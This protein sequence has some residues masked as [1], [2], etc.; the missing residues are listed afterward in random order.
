MID[1]RKLLLMIQEQKGMKANMSLEFDCEID[2]EDPKPL[3]KVINYVI[4]YL[5]A[6]TDMPLEIS[7]NPHRSGYMIG[8]A[9]HTEKT[10][11]PPLSD[12][13]DEALRLYNGSIERTGEPGKYVRIIITFS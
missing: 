1:L 3:V 11:L 4:N 2:T 5:S 9:V 10:D 7:L 12:Q 13:L 6:L 8:F